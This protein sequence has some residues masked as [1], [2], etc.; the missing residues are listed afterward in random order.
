MMLRIPKEEY[1]LNFVRWIARKL[2][3]DTMANIDFN[4]LHKVSKEISA[5]LELPIDG[6]LV[7]KECLNN[8]QIRESFDGA[9]YLIAINNNKKYPR[10]NITLL[11]LLQLIDYGCLNI[12]GYNILSTQFNL[13]SANVAKYYKEYQRT[14]FMFGA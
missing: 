8:I 14:N 11:R 6:A 4:K 2:R 12:K 1:S 13:V 9:Y 10:T 5:Y 7:L 3:M